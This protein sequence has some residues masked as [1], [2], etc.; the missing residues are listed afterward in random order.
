[1]PVNRNVSYYTQQHQQQMNNKLLKQFRKMEMVHDT[2]DYDKFDPS[3]DTIDLQ[4]AST[5]ADR[6]QLPVSE[7]YLTAAGDGDDDAHAWCTR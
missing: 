6:N 1:M 7:S 5:V 2:A 3:H 4:S